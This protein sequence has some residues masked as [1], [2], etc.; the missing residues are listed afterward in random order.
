MLSHYA[1]HLQQAKDL[2]QFTD[3][4]DG[5]REKSIIANSLKAIREQVVPQEQLAKPDMMTQ[6][7]QLLQQPDQQPTAPVADETAYA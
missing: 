4:Q 7:E 5:N 3:Q 1:G 6:V 2:K